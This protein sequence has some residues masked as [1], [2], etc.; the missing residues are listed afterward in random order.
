MTVHGLDHTPFVPV[1]EICVQSGITC[2]DPTKAFHL[3]ELQT[4][5][6]VVPSDTLHRKVWRAFNTDK[7]AEP[8]AFAVT[9]T[10]AALIKGASWLDA[11]L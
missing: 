2:A 1:S 5:A 8:T 10:L 6:V 7:V 3:A 9:A 4:A 11:R